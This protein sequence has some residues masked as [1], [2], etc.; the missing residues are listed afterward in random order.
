MLAD[1]KSAIL[2]PP[3]RGLS[4]RSLASAP[5]EKVTLASPARLTSALTTAPLR[6]QLFPGVGYFH[7]IRKKERLLLLSHLVRSENRFKSP[8]DFGANENSF[9]NME[10]K[11]LGPAQPGRRTFCGVVSLQP[12]CRAGTS[13]VMKQRKQNSPAFRWTV[14]RKGAAAAF[15]SPPDTLGKMAQGACSAPWSIFCRLT[16]G[17]GIPSLRPTAESTDTA[18]LLIPEFRCRLRG[19][20]GMPLR[21]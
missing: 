3:G 7:S 1:A 8:L 6:Y 9:W 14:P 10:G 13:F 5:P 20:T 12:S 19:G 4:A 11:Y 21:G 16:H 18:A 17:G 2:Q 15:V